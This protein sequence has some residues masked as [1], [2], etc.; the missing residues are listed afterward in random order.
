MKFHAGVHHVNLLYS[1][2]EIE[3]STVVCCLANGLVAV[4][5]VAHVLKR[6]EILGEGYDFF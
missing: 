5:N 6:Y 2:K 1:A 3:M 4:L